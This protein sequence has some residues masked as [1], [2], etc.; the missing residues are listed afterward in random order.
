[1][2]EATAFAQC[3]QS[4]LMKAVDLDHSFS[5]QLHNDLRKVCWYTVCTCISMKGH[6]VR[7]EA[8]VEYTF[9]HFLYKEFNTARVHVIYMYI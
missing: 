9:A 5:L 1:M 4:V 8:N 3:A 7:I 6:F 2:T